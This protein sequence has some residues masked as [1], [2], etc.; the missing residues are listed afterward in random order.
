MVRF[1]GH[2]RLIDLDTTGLQNNA[3]DWDT[4]TG[5]DL[6]NIANTELVTVDCHPALVT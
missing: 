3:V 1:T 2:G 4:H 6:D 5:L